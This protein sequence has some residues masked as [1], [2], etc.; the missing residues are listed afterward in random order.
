R[1]KEKGLKPGAKEFD[2][3]FD[4]EMEEQRGRVTGRLFLDVPQRRYVCF[5]PMNKRRGE[6]KNWYAVPVEERARMMRD[7]G[8]IGRHYAG[9]ALGRGGDPDY[10]GLDRLRRLGM[11]CRPLRRRPA[12]VQEI[13]L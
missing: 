7:H 4:A 1:L 3:A 12:R 13:D 6:Q 9:A 5:Y 2:A 11:G 10:L 8:V